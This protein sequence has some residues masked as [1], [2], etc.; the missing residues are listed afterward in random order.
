MPDAGE[1]SD[2]SNGPSLAAIALL[3]E[4]IKSRPRGS[5]QN[6]SDVTGAARVDVA[7]GGCVNAAAF[8]AEMGVNVGGTIK[9]GWGVTIGRAVRDGATSTGAE[10]LAR[11]IK[12]NARN[13]VLSFILYPFNKKL[14]EGSTSSLY[15]YILK[16]S[17]FYQ[18][19]LGSLPQRP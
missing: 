17:F 2:E 15:S 3:K 16:S 8:G 11:V 18:L 7:E 9:V 14:A 13:N 1:T 6:A 19:N 10:Q 4:L 12:V 5:S